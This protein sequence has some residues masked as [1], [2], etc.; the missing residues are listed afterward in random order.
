MIDREVVE[1]SD[2]GPILELPLCHT[3]GTLHNEAVGW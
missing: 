1:R 2:N 3:N